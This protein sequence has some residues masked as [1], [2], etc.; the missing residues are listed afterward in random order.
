[1]VKRE[2]DAIVVMGV[3]GC[4][5]TTI[6]TAIA[7]TLGYQFLEGDDFHPP[8]NVLKMASGQALSDT[9]RLPFL[10][11][12][13]QALQQHR[14]Q[15]VVVSCSALKRSYRDL[16]RGAGPLTFIHLAPSQ[17]A[18][19]ERL[20]RRTAHYMPAS[21]LDSQLAALEQL[22]AD[23][24]GLTL[25]GDRPV[26]EQLRHIYDFLGISQLREPRMIEPNCDIGV[27]GL[28]VMGE[29]LALNIASKGHSVAVYNRSAQ[30][31][32]DFT[33]RRAKD[34]AIVAAT[35]LPDFVAR[36][37]APRKIMMLVKAGEAVDNLLMQ[38][39][40]LLTKG[41]I[42]IDGGN[43][44][45]ADTTRRAQQM[46]A[47]GIRYVGSGVSGGEEGALNGPSLMPGG[48]TEAW[49]F[50]RPIFE[51]ICARTPNGDACCSWIGADGSGHF[52][53]MVHNGIEYGDMQIIAE[54]YDLMRRGLGMSNAEM[55]TVFA[56]WNGGE[57]NSYLIDI[58]A[59]ILKHR[60]SSGQAV[61][62]AIL[63]TA[64]Q[65]GTGKWMVGNALD[66]GVPLTL[67]TESVFARS[68]A[69]N[70]EL[71]VAAALGLGSAGTALA[72]TRTSFLADLRQA[73]YASKIVSYAQG[74]QLLAAASKD[75]NWQLNFGAIAQTWRGGC[76][77]RSAFLDDIKAA[78]EQT[79]DLPHLLL[80]PKFKQAIQTRDAA[81]R[82]VVIAA[83]Q[84]G[85]AVPCLSA[86]LTHWDA[87]RTERS[88]ANL[89]QAQRDF[90][91]AHNYERIDRPR[92]EFFHTDWTGMGGT[93]TSQTYTK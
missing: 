81:W 37:R 38:L 7:Q 19:T 64:G 86:A 68:L 59:R 61:L 35:T 50:I 9:D 69:A 12:I 39:T 55:A 28:A 30:R 10:Q 20:T 46:Q 15:G 41:D 8:A 57:L 16:L 62:D 76:I 33:A 17:Q 32:L 2:H 27:I 23:E 60:D 58:T 14:A 48:N 47:L 34:K 18:L 78:Y 13:K 67:I 40:P 79:D 45:F 54:S 53:K 66:H 91:G 93:T 56:D 3:S 24:K 85:I 72:T 77:I 82:R 92:G 83:T 74:F 89:L 11:G 25:S 73:L 87:L 88:P 21:L 29:N 1:M 80:A 42:L 70:K 31:T 71:R 84:A 22:D 6:G 51:S 65:K 90:F 49:S 5:K 4:G 26:N 44:Y 63:D 75:Y 52:V 36:L 43:T